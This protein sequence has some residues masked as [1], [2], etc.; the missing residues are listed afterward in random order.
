MTELGEAASAIPPDLIGLLNEKPAEVSVQQ[1]REVQSDRWLEALDGALLNPRGKERLALACADFPEFAPVCRK[2]LLQTG[3]GNALANEIR[4]ET[5]WSALQSMI[6]NS[7]LREAGTR[8][9]FVRRLGPLL[10]QKRLLFWCLR[11]AFS[12]GTLNALVA[13]FA[14]REASVRLEAIKA[15][16]T[17]DISAAEADLIYALDD[18]SDQVRSRALQDLK[19]RVRPERLAMITAE[20]VDEAGR[21]SELVGTAR[22]QILGLYK[23]IPG[24]ETVLEA[25]RASSRGARSALE[26]VSNVASGA[27]ASAAD[28]ASSVGSSL[29]EKFRKRAG[30]HDDG[31]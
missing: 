19:E 4:S 22:Q 31:E 13:M 1:L 15:L 24:V 11:V 2:L 21:L 23:R 26:S 16:E 5:N 18:T 10:V 7:G 3:F 25:I 6:D 29:S 30:K 12:R 9:E 28:V 27:A 20:A 14:D 8:D 17:Y